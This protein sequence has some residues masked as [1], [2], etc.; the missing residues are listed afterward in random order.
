ME[1]SARQDAKNLRVS[2]KDSGSGIA[3][4]N[5]VKLFQ[6]LFTT[7]ARSIGL[8]LVVVQNLTKANG[9]NI[10]VQS[11]LGKG[12]VFDVTFPIAGSGGNHD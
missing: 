7:K 11:E 12:T 10:E 1:I 4:E 3:P 5:L 2:V 6:P 8:G 9:G